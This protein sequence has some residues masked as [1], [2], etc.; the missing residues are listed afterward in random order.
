MSKFKTYFLS[1]ILALSFCLLASQAQADLAPFPG[2]NPNSQPYPNGPVVL[3]PAQPSYTVPVVVGGV[4]V[5]GGISAYV[6][7]L[8]R[9]KII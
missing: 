7:Y 5:V 3:P 8:I 4:V 2:T 9:K 1:A 6:L